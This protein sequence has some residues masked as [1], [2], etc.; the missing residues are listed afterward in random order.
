MWAAGTLQ[1]PYVRSGHRWGQRMCHWPSKMPLNKFLIKIAVLVHN[2]GKGSG[3]WSYSS[4][5]MENP[6]TLLCFPLL[7][8]GNSSALGAHQNR[9]HIGCWCCL[10]L[11]ISAF[12]LSKQV[13]AIPRPRPFAPWLMQQRG[14]WSHF[15][16]A[17][18]SLASLIFVDFHAAFPTST[19]SSEL[20]L[21]AMTA[22]FRS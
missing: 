15:C 4:N 22:P 5:L 13:L 18:C 14:Y 8:A 20:S 11:C 7:P 9:H 2:R 16:A 12:C 1:Q 3:C 21:L 6:V 10:C 19:L 17:L